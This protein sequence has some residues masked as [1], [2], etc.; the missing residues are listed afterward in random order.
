MNLGYRI[1]V[2]LWARPLDVKLS[3]WQAP[4][5]HHTQETNI[6]FRNPSVDKI[7]DLNVAQVFTAVKSHLCQISLVPAMYTDVRL[8]C[9][10]KADGPVYGTWTLQSAQWEEK[11][12]M[13]SMPNRQCPKNTT[14]NRWDNAPAMPQATTGND[15]AVGDPSDP[16]SWPRPH[17]GSKFSSHFC[18]SK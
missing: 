15:K 1:Y 13:E 5:D 2:E 6:A 18:N 17:L 7:Y 16:R 3:I 12:A 8:T 10:G 11:K 14:A 4:I 9:D